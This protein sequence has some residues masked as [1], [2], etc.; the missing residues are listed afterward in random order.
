MPQTD[1]HTRH[2]VQGRQVIPASGPQATP[3]D[4]SAES[5]TNRQAGDGWR[6][7]KFQQQTKA[8]GPRTLYFPL[9]KGLPA[10]EENSVIVLLPMTG[11]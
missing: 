6:R 1:G 3:G 5:G 8:V 11:P 10:W 4:T 9:I 2:P 7:G